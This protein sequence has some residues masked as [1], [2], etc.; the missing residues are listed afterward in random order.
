MNSHDLLSPLY[1]LLLFSTLVSLGSGILCLLAVDNS[2][3]RSRL[4]VRGWA[5]LFAGLIGL[6]AMIL[7]VRL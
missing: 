1:F 7:G 6:F 5:F 4:R 3:L 2:A